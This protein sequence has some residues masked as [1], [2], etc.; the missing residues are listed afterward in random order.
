M[1]Q[2]RRRTTAAALHPAAADDAGSSP[3]LLFLFLF[4]IVVIA[5]CVHLS[6]SKC[7]LLGGIVATFEAGRA[8]PSLW[9]R[10]SLWAHRPL[11][12]Y[13]WAD[14]V[15]ASVPRPGLSAR[16][17]AFLRPADS[18]AL[19]FYGVMY[20]SEGN[21]KSTAVRN[22][23]RSLPSPKGVVYYSAEA[24]GGHFS[25]SLA[26]AVGFTENAHPGDVLAALKEGA[27]EFRV[28]HGW[29]AVLVIDGADCIAR[30]DADFFHA[31]QLV[32]KECAT[33][34]SLRIVFV[35]SE[36]R[37]LRTLAESSAWLR[38]DLPLG[39]DSPLRQRPAEGLRAPLRT[40]SFHP[41]PPTPLPPPVRGAGH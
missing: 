35:V 38:A 23:V 36:G 20:G 30:E 33:M 10:Q 29:P 28:K 1:L 27:H 19:L 39:A 31:L 12:L 41:P 22:A 9:A 14:T 18:A 15:R 40:A 11:D 6:A 16:I 37:T 24:C 32:A 17:A 13:L 7:G 4:S 5:I 2:R 25:S 21:G 34:G 8:C 26:V 3:A